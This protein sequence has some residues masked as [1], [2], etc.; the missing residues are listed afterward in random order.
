MPNNY[1][2]KTNYHSFIA[3][4]FSVILNE[5]KNLVLRLT[6]YALRPTQYAPL[7]LFSSAI[8]FP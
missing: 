5:V 7:P 6:L 8:L 4:L 2:V 3:L 1:H